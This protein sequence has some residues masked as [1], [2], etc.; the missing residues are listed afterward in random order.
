MDPSGPAE[1]T[2]PGQIA[3]APGEWQLYW[4]VNGIWGR[5][6]GTLKAS[7]GS[8]FR[9]SRSVD[10]FVPRGGGW[11]FVALARECDFGALPGW[12]GPGHPTAP[13]P[14]TNEV[15]NA[16]GDDYP[17]AIAV[18]YRGLALGRHVV[19]ASTAGSTCPRSNTKG[20]YQLTYTVFR[21]R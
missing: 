18:A 13:C 7:D 17:G 16:K 5:W 2:L 12:N 3:S 14:Q 21:V 15:G 19:D 20:C 10:F 1:S 6:P 8:T 11:T 9:G 4:S